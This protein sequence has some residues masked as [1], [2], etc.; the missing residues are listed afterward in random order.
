MRQTALKLLLLVVWPFLACFLAV[1]I[2]FLLVSVWFLIPF[3]RI[4]KKA[5]GKGYKMR[6]PWGE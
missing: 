4:E 1:C 6:M 2:L 3:S 5:G